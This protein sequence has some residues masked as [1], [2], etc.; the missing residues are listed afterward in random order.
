M[1]FSLPNKIIYRHHIVACLTK[2]PP[3]EKKSPESP[4]NNLTFVER[5]WQMMK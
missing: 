3:F 2:K 4:F 1:T 5:L